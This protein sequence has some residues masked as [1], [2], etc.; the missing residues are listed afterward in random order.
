M[1]LDAWD[2]NIMASTGFTINKLRSMSLSQSKGINKEEIFNIIQNDESNSVS[3]V[4][5][6]KHS[7]SQLNTT[8]QKLSKKVDDLNELKQKVQ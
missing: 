7:I 5:T 4:E 6:F 2:L 1:C 8:I 3:E